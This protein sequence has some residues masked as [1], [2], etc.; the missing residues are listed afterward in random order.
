MTEQGGPPSD[1]SVPAK[2]IRASDA[3]RAAV[4]DRLNHACTEGR[5]T[6]EEF[7]ERVER[8]YTAKE[9]GELDALVADL[10]AGRPER[11]V[12]RP[13]P[14]APDGRSGGDSQVSVLPIG[15]MRRR[16]RWHVRRNTVLVT[17]LGGMDLDLREADI[18]ADEVTLTKVSLVGGLDVT[19]P[20]GVRVE[21]GGFVLLGGRTIDVGDPAAP[22]APTIRIRA[23]GLVG[24]VRVRSS[25][26]LDRWRRALGPRGD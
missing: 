23:F 25:R 24:G 3:E 6:L 12:R 13:A 16:G 26:P 17:L 18:T 15:G 20:P 22:G 9:R 10:P 1:D 19:V 5:L 8:V 21:I 4:V 11:P 7:S 14:E 2:A